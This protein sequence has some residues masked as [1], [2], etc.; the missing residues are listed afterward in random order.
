MYEE[1][2]TDTLRITSPLH[3]TPAAYDIE[4]GQLVRELS[5]D[6]YLTYVTQSG[7]DIVVQFVTA[8]G[9]CYGQL[10][11]GRQCGVLADLP[12]LCDVYDGE[13]YFDYPTGNVRK[14]RIYGIEELISAAREGKYK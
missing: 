3:G 14:S 7:D 1:F 8:D 12:Y 4:S 13:L 11:D 2:T 10:L 5:Q 9:Y 6:A